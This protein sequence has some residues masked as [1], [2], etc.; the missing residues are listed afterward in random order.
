MREGAE[1]SLANLVSLSGLM[2][3]LAAGV[4][5]GRETGV[6]HSSPNV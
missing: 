3:E 5:G 2:G 1:E 6:L 4:G